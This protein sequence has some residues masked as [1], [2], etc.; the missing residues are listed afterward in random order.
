MKEFETLVDR[1]YEAATNADLWP[2]VMHDLGETVGA[3]G[4]IILARRSDAWLG[5]R[6]SPALEGVDDYL[7]SPA[8]ARSQATTRLI[9]ANR[10]GF[11]DAHEVFTEEEWIADPLMTTWGA[12]PPCQRC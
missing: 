2:Q 6:Y 9:A 8:V 1:I 3:A 12:R 4:G 5:W 7:N 10:A 11:V